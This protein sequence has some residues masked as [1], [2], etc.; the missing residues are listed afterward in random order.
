MQ[1]EKEKKKKKKKELQIGNSK[2]DWK[3]ERREEG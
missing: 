1:S 2:F 3:R